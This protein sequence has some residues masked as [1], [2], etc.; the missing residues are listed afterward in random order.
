VPRPARLIALSLLTLPVLAG[1]A[2]VFPITDPLAGATVDAHEVLIT[3]SDVSELEGATAAE[4]TEPFASNID[5]YL[6][7]HATGIPSIEPGECGDAVVDLVLLDRDAG[8]AGTIYSAPRVVLANGY[9]LLQTGR[10]FTS[11]AEA[12]AWF[13]DYRDLIES[14]PS[15]TVHATDGDIV[16]TQ[17]VADAGYLIDGFVVRLE[18]EAPPGVDTPDFNEQ[19]ML[20]AGPFAVLVSSASDDPDDDA[21]LPAVDAIQARLVAA[22]AAA[23][24]DEDSDR[25]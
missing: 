10:E 25:P 14:C 19:W 17:R 23:A 8:A 5:D 4:A 6:A 3:G 13:A 15:F 24:A 20:R 22:V 1:C 16:V 21:L 18:I 7:L 11:A 12:D 9:E 2:L